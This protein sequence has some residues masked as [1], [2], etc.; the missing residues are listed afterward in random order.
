MNIFYEADRDVFWILHT[1]SLHFGELKFKERI[2]SGQKHLEIFYDE[3][4]WAARI[5]ELGGNPYP[6]DLDEFIYG[7]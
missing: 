2:S 6:E 1:P 3:E 5:L 4:S 7:E